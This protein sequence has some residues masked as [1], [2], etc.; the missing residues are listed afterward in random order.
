MTVPG[1]D[2]VPDANLVFDRRAAI[3]GTPEQVWPWIVQLGKDRGGWYLPARVER[4]QPPAFRAT[5]AIDPGWQTLAVGDRV[6][7]WGAPGAH[8][9]FEVAL[10]QP[11]HTLVYRAQRH[12]TEFSWALLLTATGA[13]ETELRLRFRGRLKSSG[14]LRRAIIAGGGFFDWATGALMIAGLRERVTALAHP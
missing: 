12:R 2:I 7:D 5:R 14:L 9:F 3:P 8:E 4:W 10:V 6:P 11:P 1:D 13:A